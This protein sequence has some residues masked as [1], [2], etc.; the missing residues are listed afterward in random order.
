MNKQYQDLTTAEKIKLKLSVPKGMVEV[1]CPWW[2]KGH[3]EK[4]TTTEFWDEA[5]YRII[6]NPA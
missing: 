6:E 3:W 4:K 2:P 5:T 1:N